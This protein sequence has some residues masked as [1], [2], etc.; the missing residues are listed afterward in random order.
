VDGRIFATLIGAATGLASNLILAPLKVQ[1]A[2][3]AI[4]DM[5]RRLAGLLDEM[6]VDLAE[7]SGADHTADWVARSRELSAE[8]EQAEQ[9]LGQAE[10]S[11]KLNPRG[12]LVVDPRVYL[13]RRLEAL[14]H[15]TVTIRGIALSL[16]DSV[17]LSDE[18]NPV[19][20]RHAAS[21]VADVLRELAAALRA[22]GQ[23]A[24][25][26]SVDR[27]SLK[28]AVDQHLASA[29][30]HQGAVADIMRADPAAPSRGWPLRGELVTH[31][32]RLRAELQP[33]PPRNSGRTGVNRD[34]RL[35][36]AR[37]IADR[38]NHR[39]NR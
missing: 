22:Y 17:E 3:E 35:R 32:D 30:E 39:G 6:S 27:G 23:L 8:M 12:P 4:D 10:E 34:R 25:S 21:R 36:P 7:G 19:R 14:E 28:S 38:W 26:K 37:A 18:V 13:R 9:A 33:A 2:E 20:D 5:G 1:P 31:L 15:A 24:H 16:N 11:V 29:S